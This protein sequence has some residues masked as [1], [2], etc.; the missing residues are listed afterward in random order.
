MNPDDNHLNTDRVGQKSKRPKRTNKNVNEK[1]EE[2]FTGTAT[3]FPEQ[4]QFLPPRDFSSGCSKAE[5]G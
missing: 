1:L 2:A 5:T 4:T 3:I